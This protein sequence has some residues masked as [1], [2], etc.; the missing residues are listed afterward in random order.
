M[1]KIEKYINLINDCVPSA[2]FIFTNGKCYY[3]YLLLRDK[4]KNEYDVKPYN[5]LGHIYTL[6]NGNFYDI[7]GKHYFNNDDMPVPLERFEMENAHRNKIKFEVNC[8]YNGKEL[9][10]NI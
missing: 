4:F 2:D 6:I 5:Y 10:D 7:N 8:N 3:F 1:D 9:D